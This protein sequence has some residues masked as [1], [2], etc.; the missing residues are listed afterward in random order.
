MAIGEDPVDLEPRGT[1]GGHLAVAVREA[2]VVEG[3][4]G[5]VVRTS[6]APMTSVPRSSAVV[7]FVGSAPD[8]TATPT[9]SSAS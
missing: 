9:P 6:P 8:R 7:L 4:P 1:R 3:R 2:V 5:I